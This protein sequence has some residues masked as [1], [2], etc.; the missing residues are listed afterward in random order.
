MFK[1]NKNSEEWFSEL[2]QWVSKNLERGIENALGK[3]DQW[4]KVP[5]VPYLLLFVLSALVSFFIYHDF[6]TPSLGYQLNE[7]AQRFVISPK[8]LEIE[9]PEATGKARQTRVDQVLDVYDLDQNKFTAQ[10]RRFDQS[11]E[12]LRKA[13]PDLISAKEPE[14]S[15]NFNQAFTEFSKESG[16]DLKEDQFHGLLNLSTST[17]FER[18][19]YDILQ[20]VNNQLITS[21]KELINENRE[22]GISL[23]R[24]SEDKTIEEVVFKDFDRVVSW[25]DSKANLEEWGQNTFSWIRRPTRNQVLSLAKKLVYPNLTFNQK[26]TETRKKRA[27]NQAQA[28]TFKV[29]KGEV[30]VRMHDVVTERHLKILHALQREAG[31]ENSVYKYLFSTFFVF[32]I[33]VSLAFLLKD[34][35]KPLRSSARDLFAIGSLLI[36]SIIPANFILYV[37]I[38]AFKNNEYFAHIPIEFFHYFMPVASGAILVRMLMGKEIAAFFSILVTILSGLLIEKDYFYICYAIVTCFVGLSFA[39]RTQTRSSLYFVGLKLGI[40]N[41]IFI[42]TI[43]AMTKTFAFSEIFSESM[44]WIVFGGFLNGVLSSVLAGIVAPL[45]ENLFGYV[46][47]IKLLELANLENPLL[48]ELLVR[49][50]GTYHHS[51]MIGNLVETAAEAIGA[52]PLLARVMAMYHDIGKMIK[53]HYF[54]ENQGG[55]ANPHDKLTPSMSS[56]VIKEHVWG[57]IDLGKKY[58]IPRV[59]IAGIPEHHGTLKITYFH[60]RYMQKQMEIGEEATTKAAEAIFRHEGPKP[61]SKETALLMLADGIEAATRSIKEPTLQKIEGMVHRIFQKIVEDGQLNEVDLTL[62]D[63]NKIQETFIKQIANIHHHR[64]EYDNA[65]KKHSEYSNANRPPNPGNGT[66][67]DQSEA[68]SQNGRAHLKAIDSTSSAPVP[69][70]SSGKRSQEN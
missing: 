44:R 15:P 51:M 66:K 67:E 16:I 50:P 3:I 45:F 25:E 8:T 9:D 7:V 40:F 27:L 24:S 36:L 56:M 10:W 64:I 38:Q 58:R 61:H 62:Q 31:R 11:L 12:R 59:I 65:P 22:K 23:I 29:E 17:R 33:F 14:K 6:Y 21:N 26:E 53:P 13:Y 5:F 47:D 52:N 35:F 19:L 32:L 54:I 39:S 70:P 48:K 30:V 69:P 46:S 60:N 37:S 28:V 1:Q 4:I 18:N 63:L 41:S 43:L 20:R 55:S 42:C 57:G 2:S 49:A 68:L 34:G